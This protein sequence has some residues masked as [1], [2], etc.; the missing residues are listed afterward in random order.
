[1]PL[2]Y[3]KK[4]DWFLSIPFHVLLNALGW[5]APNHSITCFTQCHC[6]TSRRQIGSYPYHYMFYTMPLGRLV[7]N[8]TI[9][10]FTECQWEDWFLT[11]PF[12]VLLNALGWLAPNHSVTCFT[13]CHCDTS[14]RQIGSYPF[15]YM[16]YTMPLVYLKKSDCITCFTHCH[17]ETPG[18]QI[19]S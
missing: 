17:W 7:L 12:H 8:H 4:T 9:T 1:M 13:Q 19:G 15:H 3:L 16:F 5:L 14:R 18:R 2:W 6:D 10:C 11:I